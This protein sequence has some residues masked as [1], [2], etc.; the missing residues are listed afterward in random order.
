MVFS[1]E[2][3]LDY[4]ASIGLFSADIGVSC[5]VHN[6]GNDMSLR[7]G[8]DETKNYY[9]SPNNPLARNGFLVT[10][11]IS[12]LINRLEVAV[13]GQIIGEVTANFRGLPQGATANAHVKFEV[14]DI[15]NLFQNAAGA[16]SGR[17]LEVVRSVFK[18]W[19]C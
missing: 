3:V 5:A 1:A 2:A 15:N 16:F 8:L 14:S 10:D 17:C 6:H 13:A 7:F 12:D 4:I 19:Q 18:S 11:G 9:L